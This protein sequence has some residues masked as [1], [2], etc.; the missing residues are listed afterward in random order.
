[1]TKGEEQISEVLIIGGGII[2]LSIARELHKR[3][4]GKITIIERGKTGQESSFAA[5]GML[6]PNAETDKIDVFF[7]FC[8]ESAKLYPNF[9]AELF[10][11]TGIDIE[12]DQS[13]TLY[14]AFNEKDVKEI[15][16]RFEW[17]SKNGLEIAHLPAQEIL[18]IEPFVSPKVCEGLFFPNDWQVE[19]RKLMAALQIYAEKN[20]IKILENTDVN[21]LLINNGKISGVETEEGKL[22]AGQ[23]ILATGAWTTLIKSDKFLMPEI[24]PIR[25]QMLCFQSVQKQFSKVIYSPRGYIVPRS[26]GRILAGATVEKTGFD[27]SV[28]S[29]GIDSVLKTSFEIAPN[30]GQIKIIEKW[31][32]LRPLSDDGFPILGAIPE[33]ENLF[34]ATGHFRNGILL[35]PLT[36]KILA[37]KI[38]KNTENQYLRDFS[39]HRFQTFKANG[40]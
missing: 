1:M 2:G 21:K 15:H 23:V 34:I 11:E 19:N 36:A 25:G 29:A 7:Y 31:A 6:A 30:L 12:L 14:L 40:G 28:T 10:D 32:G 5:A 8:R 20:Q 22:S 27:K 4:V 9:S 18:K 26:D 38:A 24:Q 35:A 37:D 39:P 13:G 16:H 17:Q 3:S 33:I